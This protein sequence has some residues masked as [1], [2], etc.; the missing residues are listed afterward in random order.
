MNL[1]YLSCIVVVINENIQIVTMWLSTEVL[2]VLD[3]ALVTME[4]LYKTGTVTVH[5]NR[6]IN[7]QSYFDI[8]YFIDKIQTS[9]NQTT[10]ELNVKHEET[11]KIKFNLPMAD[12]D[13]HK[14][15]L[16]FCNIDLQDNMAHTKVLLDE[17]LNLLKVIERIYSLLIKLEVSG[18][19]NY[20]LKEEKFEIFDQTGQLNFDTFE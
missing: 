10:D 16:T 6:L 5:L 13:D 15:Q 17:Q 8:E 18:H 12:I 2:T 3:N 4:Y 11:T 20:Q 14:R 7:E 1:I 19:P 9:M